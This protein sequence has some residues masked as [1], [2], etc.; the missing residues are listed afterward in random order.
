MQLVY[1]DLNGGLKLL[2]LDRWNTIQQVLEKIAE[3]EGLSS[4]VPELCLTAYGKSLDHTLSLSSYGLC[5][6]HMVCLHVK[7]SHIWMDSAQPSCPTEGITVRVSSAD[8]RFSYQIG[9][10]F[11]IESL[12]AMI[13]ARQCIPVDKQRLTFNGTRVMEFST[14]KDYGIKNG[15]MLIVDDM[16]NECIIM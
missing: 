15:D 4:R 16:R 10:P 3:N 13:Q 7:T 8:G 14:L 12:M 9:P 6:G 1:K 5:E 2:V 11:T